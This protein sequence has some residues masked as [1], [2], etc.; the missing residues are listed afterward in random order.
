[1]V[2]GKTIGSIN[3]FY[4][5]S[6]GYTYTDDVNLAIANLGSATSYSSVS[7][8]SYGL[9][10]KNYN[11]IQSSS[12]SGVVTTT[13]FYGTINSGGI[14]RLNLNG[15]WTP[16]GITQTAYYDSNNDF[17][18]D[19]CF[20]AGG[21]LGFGFYFPTNLFLP[22]NAILIAASLDLTLT[23]GVA[24]NS[25]ND[26]LAI[27]GYLTPGNLVPASSSYLM[28][29]LNSTITEYYYIGAALYNT[30]LSFRWSNPDFSLNQ[31]ARSQSL[32]NIGDLGLF[33]KFKLHISSS[34][35]I[36]G[37]VAQIKP[38]FYYIF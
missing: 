31:S 6:G 8:G 22:K 24:I 11:H 28:Q 34:D 29:L 2:N 18:T 37:F 35:S 21:S 10:D 9:V 5:S 12:V 36:T 27:D 3:R 38:K 15:F 20:S 23:N 1:M 13:P 14:D 33:I 16:G 25:T 32:Y 19:T 26:F 30:A 17:Y 4:G 7:P